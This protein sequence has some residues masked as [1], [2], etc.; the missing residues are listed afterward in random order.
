MKNKNKLVGLEGEII[1]LN[2]LRKKG[3]KIIEKNFRCKVG[4]VDLV[5]ME[6]EYLVFVEVKTRST[7]RYG[8]PS[9]AINY[10]KQMK[11]PAIAT[12]F[13]KM[14]K[15]FDTPVR[16][17]IVEVIRVDKDKYEINLIKNAFDASSAN[18]YY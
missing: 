17:D 13:I 18:I 12:I 6:G 7:F 8:R 5:C 10:Y 11:Y 16:F 14:N 2:Y 4:E 15:M 9:D 3:Y 1:A